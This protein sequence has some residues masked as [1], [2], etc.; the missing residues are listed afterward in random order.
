MN[1]TS[2]R[3]YEEAYDAWL[4]GEETTPEES[5]QLQTRYYEDATFRSET[6][7]LRAAASFINQNLD[8]ILALFGPAVEISPEKHAEIWQNFHMRREAERQQQRSVRSSRARAAQWSEAQWDKFKENLEVLATLAKRTME[9]AATPSALAMQAASSQT[10][11]QAAQVEGDSQ[12][13]VPMRVYKLEIRGT[14]VGGTVRLEMTL[15]GETAKQFA[16]WFVVTWLDAGVEGWV[17]IGAT[18]VSAQASV[19]GVLRED[20]FPLRIEL[21]GRL[22]FTLRRAAER[23][24]S[25]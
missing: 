24:K 4:S 13:T 10:D 21:I 11:S 8:P 12:A 19:N 3:T 2:N 1:F 15:E 23:V 9:N 16:G 25:E 14:Q 18:P 17:E 22:R 7:Q 20:R 6:D 5:E